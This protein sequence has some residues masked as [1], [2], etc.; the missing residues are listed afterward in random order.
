MNPGVKI[1]PDRSIA[2]ASASLPAAAP[3]AAI[4]LCLIRT[5]P[6]ISTRFEETKLPFFSSFMDIRTPRLKYI[7]R[8]KPATC[9]AAGLW[10]KF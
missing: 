1:L 5:E 8:K 4:R 3:T 7:K 9:S 10:N 6:A 2:S